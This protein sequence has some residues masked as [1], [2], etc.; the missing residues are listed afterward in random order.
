MVVGFTTTYAISWID[1]YLCYQCLSPLKLRVR[2]SLRPGV[3]D[4]ILCDKV[5]Q[6]LSASRWF[7]LGTPVSCSNKIDRR[8]ITKIL[9]ILALNTINH[10]H[11][12]CTIVIEQF[13]LQN[14]RTFNNLLRWGRLEY[15]GFYLDFNN[16]FELYFSK[17][18]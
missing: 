15:S 5:C 17:I 16:K 3:L 13:S 18:K 2:T 8:N 7:S 9:L 6:R 12:C 14:I 11:N 10:W 4:T 1:N